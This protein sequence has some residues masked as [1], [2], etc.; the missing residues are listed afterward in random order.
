MKFGSFYAGDHGECNGVGFKEISKIFEMHHSFYFV[1]ISL[2]TSLVAE[3]WELSKLGM[4]VFKWCCW[5]PIRAL[6][7][8]CRIVQQTY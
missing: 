1:T 6:I 7:D 8:S 4:A 5:R 2:D 3:W